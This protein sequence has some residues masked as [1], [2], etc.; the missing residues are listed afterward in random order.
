M[1]KFNLCNT[2][3]EYH[4]SDEQCASLFY[5]KHERYGEEF[6]PIYA[7]SYEHAAT[8]FAEKHDNMTGHELLEENLEEDD[9]QHVIISN[10]TIEKKFR[11][12]GEVVYEYFADE[13][14]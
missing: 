10:G 4:Y 7:Y 13:I 5:F 9:Y 3:N 14:K 1:H 8:K 6:H 11:I 2:C 12:F